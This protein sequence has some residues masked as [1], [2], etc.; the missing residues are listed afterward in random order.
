[1]SVVIPCYD[2]VATIGTVI[3]LVLAQQE[4][5]EIIV[6]DDGSKDGSWDVIQKMC[7]TKTANRWTM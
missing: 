2:E 1:V 3:Q 5:Q 4:V 7:A 6:V